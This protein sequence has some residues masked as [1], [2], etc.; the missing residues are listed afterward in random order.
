MEEKSTLFNRTLLRPEEIGIIPRIV[1]IGW[2]GKSDGINPGN[3]TV[4]ISKYGR[5]KTTKTREK[6]TI[7]KSKDFSSYIDMFDEQLTPKNK[8]SSTNGSAWF[9]I[10]NMNL[11]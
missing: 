10:D 1:R 2:R 6:K 7:L 11:V 5:L 9:G 8:R 4:K 3:V